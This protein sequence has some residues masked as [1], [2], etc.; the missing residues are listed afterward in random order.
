[1]SRTDIDYNKKAILKYMFKHARSIRNHRFSAMNLKRAYLAGVISGDGRISCFPP[2]PTKHMRTTVL[3]YNQSIPF[4]N[5]LKEM[6]CKEF[7]VNG[8]ISPKKGENCF[9]LAI[10]SRAFW[11]Y[12]ASNVD[13]PLDKK[14]L[15]VPPSIQT[16]KL[17]REYLAGL[18]DTDGYLSYTFGIM[19]SKRNLGYLKKISMLC[20]KYYGLRFGK[21]SINELRQNGKTYGRVI[22][23]LRKADVRVFIKNIPLRHEKYI[24]RIAK[25]LRGPV[26]E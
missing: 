16:K 12:L 3:I 18:F 11:I 8:R 9:E 7:G 26:V 17:F 15:Q 13:L 22:M 20:R 6:I 19:L 10:Y 25:V 5:Y 1:M 21:I 4:L 24:P 2:F 14:Y 23:H